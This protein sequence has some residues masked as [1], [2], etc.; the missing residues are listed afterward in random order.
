MIIIQP[1]KILTMFVAV[2][3]TDVYT[4]YFPVGQT[5]VYVTCGRHSGHAGYLRD[6]GVFTKVGQGTWE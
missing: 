2:N 3:F 1:G 5:Y 6:T 4:T